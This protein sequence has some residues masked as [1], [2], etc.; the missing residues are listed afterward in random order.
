[1]IAREKFLAWCAVWCCVSV[2]LAATPGP[3]VQVPAPVSKAAA[4]SA[5][6]I[7]EGYQYARTCYYQLQQ[8]PELQKQ[9]AQWDECVRRFRRIS[10]R[11]PDSPRAPDAL[12]TIAKTFE[13]RFQISHDPKH[14]QTAIATYLNAAKNYRTHALA[15]DALYRA[16]IVYAEGLHEPQKAK[17]MMWRV[18]RWYGTGDMAPRA[19]AFLEGQ[20]GQGSGVR[21]SDATTP[22]SPPTTSDARPVTI[23][24]DPGHGGSDPGAHGPGGTLEKSLTLALSKQLAS[25]LTKI[26][27]VAVSLTRTTDKTL[28]LAERN[29]IANQKKADLFISMHTN[30]AT[31]PEAHGVQTYYLNNAT[32]QAA[33][34]LAARENA[35]TEKSVSEIEHIVSTMLQNA[36]TDQ[37]AQLAASVQRGMLHTVRKNFSSVDDQ[38]VRSALFY[39]LVGAKS[40]AILVETSFLSNPQEEQ[41]L[42]DPLYQASLAA[43]IA[44]GVQHFLQH[45]TAH[46]ER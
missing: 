7:E 14:L 42:R 46:S 27:G 13:Q 6:G 25:A 39:V 35:S 28:S 21:G 26:P 10:E 31:S 19:K 22:E 8:Q 38:H 5:A 32:D 16:G 44:D 43:G 4:G 12:F 37:S 15:D 23:V 34:R 11:H 36:L 30:A 29:K 3:V 45:R 20:R 2:S 9:P 18:L 24:I 41:R 1:M 40:P 33:V 17:Q